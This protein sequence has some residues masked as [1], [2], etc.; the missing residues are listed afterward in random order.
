MEISGKQPGYSSAGSVDALATC[1][2][3][4][5]LAIA[6]K[7]ALGSTSIPPFNYLIAA[8]LL[9]SGAT[10]QAQ[11]LP[12]TISAADF[13]GEN[14]FIVIGSDE[15]GFSGSSV[16]GAG[17]IN[18]DGVRDII[19]GSPFDSTGQAFVV[20][21]GMGVGNSGVFDAA[22]LDGNSGF[23]INGIQSGDEAGRAVSDAGDINGD[24]F[25]DLIIGANPTLQTFYVIF[26]G[27][28]V[29]A[30]GSLELSGLDGDNGFVISTDGA[31]GFYGRSA[32]G[33]GD[34][35]GDGIDDVI[36]T[37][38]IDDTDNG[39]VVGQSHVVFGS[40]EIGVGGLLEL[41]DEDNSNGFLVTGIAL[42]DDSGPVVNSAGDVNDDGFD[43]VII[44]ASDASFDSE[45]N[46]NISSGITY[47]VFGGEDADAMGSLDVSNLDG[48]NGFSIT[49]IG[50]D[51]G[52]GFS[53][54]SAGDLNAD[55][56]DDVVVVAPRSDIDNSGSAGEGFVIF[57]SQ[58][59]GAGG[60]L[61]VSTLDGSTGFLINGT[62]N[63]TS[64]LTTVNGAGDVNGD[65]IDDIVLAADF[66]TPN[67][68]AAL[69]A[70]G[71]SYVVFGS[72]N[73]GVTGVLEL[74][75]L[76]GSNGFAVSGRTQDVRSGSSVDNNVDFNGDGMDDVIIGAGYGTTI[77][78]RSYAGETYVVFGGLV[79]PVRPNGGA[80]GNDLFEN[81]QV[82]DAANEALASGTT[83][84]VSGTTAGA[85]AESGEPAHLLTFSGPPRGPV[86]SIW[87][88]FTADAT[89]IVEVDT[90]GSA[91][92]NVISAYEFGSDTSISQLMPVGRGISR[93]GGVTR[94]RFAIRAGETYH[95]AVD[96]FGSNREG[97]IQLNLR[98]PTLDLAECT[99][100]GTDGPDV[101]TG[102]TGPDVICS[103][104]GDDVIRSLGGSDV[105]FAGSGAD[106]INS[107]A[108][109]DI[110]F[111][112]DGK[113]VLVGASGVDLLVGGALADRI[114]GGQGDDTILG[115][116][117]A[118]RLFGAAGDDRLFGGTGG[119]RLSGGEDADLLD[120]GPFIDNCVD[121]GSDTTIS[122]CE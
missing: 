80:P 50:E 84:S 94:M 29:G 111:G 38:L 79:S 64:N 11:E 26:G 91:V 9:G 67:G 74:T 114:F 118:D 121:A 53:V 36:V 20:F 62:D 42:N 1:M 83:L 45:G 100:T 105:I 115:E 108:G 48:S 8:A 85:T 49:T 2:S 102:T 40:A 93:N 47:V 69:S 109:V 103:L 55:G 90:V 33:A 3:P 17:D 68:D 24:G 120:G 72:E 96:G 58:T 73:V 22:D 14:G 44:G 57:G 104:G 52:L 19:I 98:R 7:R 75:S 35:N 113:D 56:M 39:L 54:S 116:S 5:A 77:N 59:I 18:A 32:S 41:S 21:G 107:G 92:G 46:S 6:I 34:I 119:D 63:N 89:Q 106:F 70:A 117:G 16:S 60:S 88:R 81:A 82:L 97:N 61:D 71:E 95:I 12:A 78:G 23:V 122:S 65:G 66:T 43:D 37:S 10:V 28:G 76:D 87:F 101:L 15:G 112:E 31:A 30:D 4:T 99:I 25:D 13:D 110:V 27:A 51:D 86:N